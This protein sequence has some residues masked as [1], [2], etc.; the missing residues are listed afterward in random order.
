MCDDRLRRE[1]SAEGTQ[2]E[3]NLDATDE[4]NNN[5]IL[6][7]HDKDKRHMSSQLQQPPPPAMTMTSP[8]DFFPASTRDDKRIASKINVHVNPMTFD[9]RVIFF[10]LMGF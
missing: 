4:H 2:R 5:R 6:D 3:A 8:F 1:T 9:L 10:I 7:K